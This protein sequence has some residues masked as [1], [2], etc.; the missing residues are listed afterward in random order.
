MVSHLCAPICLT[1]QQRLHWQESFLAQA[2]G[3]EAELFHPSCPVA[4]HNGTQFDPV[5]ATL[6]FQGNCLVTVASMPLYPAVLLGVALHATHTRPS[7]FA[8]NVQGSYFHSFMFGNLV[9]RHFV[10]RN[11]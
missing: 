9:D 11:F 8:S 10:S 3:S 2:P 6:P 7:I 4:C 1:F 5:C